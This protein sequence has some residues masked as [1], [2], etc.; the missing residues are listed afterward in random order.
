MA[1]NDPL[2]AAARDAVKDIATRTWQSLLGIGIASL[3]LGVIVLIW[4]AATLLVVAILFGIYLL[5]SGIFQVAATFGVQHTHG[6]WRVLSFL[7]GAI[8]ILLAFVAFRNIETAVILLAL[9]VG[10]GWIF[11][12]VTELSVF[13]DSASG[14]PG[15][16][17]GI[18][19]GIVTVIAG[20]ILIIW[21]ISSVATLTVV[22]GIMLV[23]V[24]AVEIVHAFMLRSKVKS[25]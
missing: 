23:V 11:R 1:I 25:V 16:G 4:P 15:R 8:S 6:W 5:I 21:P 13:M 7:S 14:L 12:G 3:I 9:W 10:I 20:G 18:F 19:L 2:S 17:W 22:S 24:G